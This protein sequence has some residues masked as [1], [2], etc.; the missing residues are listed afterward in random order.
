MGLLSSFKTQQ[1]LHSVGS[2]HL[3][4]GS[5]TNQR[6]GDEAVPIYTRGGQ[7]TP[8]QLLLQSQSGKG[9]GFT[10][11]NHVFIF[12]LNMFCYMAS[13]HI[14]FASVCLWHR[15]PMITT[16][17]IIRQNNVFQHFVQIIGIYEICQ[18]P[19]PFLSKHTIITL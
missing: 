14:S 5:H 7:A 18:S 4:P 1:R 16:N 6:L 11:V 12:L 3:R 17:H 2:S 13:D 8:L 15:R 19:E 9:R 10:A